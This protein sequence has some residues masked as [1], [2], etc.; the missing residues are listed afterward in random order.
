MSSVGAYFLLVVLVHILATA[1][2]GLAWYPLARAAGLPLRVGR[3][4]RLVFVGSFASSFLPSS[5][6]GDALRAWLVGREQ[7]RYLGAL[8][9]IGAQRI[10]GLTVLVALVTIATFT[11]SPAIRGIGAL[12][13]ALVV[14]ISGLVVFWLCVFGGIPVHGL[15]LLFPFRPFIKAAEIATHVSQQ[16]RDNKLAMLT[17]LVFS[18]L[19]YGLGILM[20]WLILYAMGQSVE[21]TSLTAIVPLVYLCAMLPFTINGIGIRENA[22]L[23]LLGRIGVSPA[24]ALGLSFLVSSSYLL[25]TLIGAIFFSRERLSVPWKHAE[26]SL[27]DE[28]VAGSS[29]IP[30]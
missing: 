21:W 28:P 12:Y 8:W 18:I 7:K 6:G 20:N 11:F 29:S 16:L 24:H 19:F 23:F 22:Y 4:I 10:I 2:N 9:S 27:P 30:Q 17:A 25:L 1:T 5:I 26:T 15:L 14:L 13:V 3:A